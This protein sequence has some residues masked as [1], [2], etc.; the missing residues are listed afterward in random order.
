MPAAAAS[1]DFNRACLTMFGLS[2]PDPVPLFL[3]VRGR[4]KNAG[5]AQ[6]S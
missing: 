6:R 2:I 5:P 1:T 3:L 4:L